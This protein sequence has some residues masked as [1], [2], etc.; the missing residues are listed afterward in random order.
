M[1]WTTYKC[2]SDINS[3]RLEENPKPE[4]VVGADVKA[5]RSAMACQQQ[6]S[7]EPKGA[8]VRP[9]AA[10]NS[11]PAR[12]FP[13]ARLPTKS[14]TIYWTDPTPSDSIKHI[15]PLYDSPPANFP[16]FP[17]GETSGE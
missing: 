15:L 2:V 11:K 13:S 16:G 9:A 5:T 8:M 12:P 7:L 3:G 10:M 6:N 17:R 14:R 1:R 4:I